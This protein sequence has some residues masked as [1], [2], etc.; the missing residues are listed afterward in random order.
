MFERLAFEAPATLAGAHRAK[1][2]A[3]MG[4][5]SQRRDWK[6]GQLRQLAQINRATFIE[7]RKESFLLHAGKLLNPENQGI[8]IAKNGEE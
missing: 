5:F 3:A 2:F 4:V 6:P 1:D 8:R 7:R